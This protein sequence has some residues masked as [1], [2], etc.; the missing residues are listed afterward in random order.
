MNYHERD[1]YGIYN[2]PQFSPPLMAQGPGP[3]LMGA[4]TLIGNNVLNHAGNPG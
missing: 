3:H 1:I 4:E 2:N